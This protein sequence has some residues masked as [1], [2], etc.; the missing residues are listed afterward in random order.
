MAECKTWQQVW[1]DCPLRPIAS[2]IEPMLLAPPPSAAIVAATMEQ[3]LLLSLGRRIIVSIQ[4]QRRLMLQYVPFWV[5][6]I[7]LPTTTTSTTAALTTMAPPI[8]DWVW[9][10]TVNLPDAL[11]YP[12]VHR[13]DLPFWALRVVVKHL[14]PI[15]IVQEQPTIIIWILI[16]KI[17]QSAVNQIPIHQAILA[18]TEVCILLLLLLFT[19]ITII[20]MIQKEYGTF[21]HCVWKRAFRLLAW[22]Q[23]IIFYKNRRKRNAK[24]RKTF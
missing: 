11:I 23:L 2:L 5:K 24:R 18:K 10:V 13:V 1:N 12:W 4:T 7:L 21:W 14:E 6:T 17:H 3:E 15:P 19:I 8:R 20:V 22:I 9:P 16:R